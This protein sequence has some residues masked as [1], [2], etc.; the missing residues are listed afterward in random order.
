MLSYLYTGLMGGGGG[1][2]VSNG[3]RLP[4]WGGGCSGVEE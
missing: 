3:L 2:A 4:A 1:V